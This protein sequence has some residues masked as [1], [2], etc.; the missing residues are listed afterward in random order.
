VLYRD[1][2]WYNCFQPLNYCLGGIA[3]VLSGRIGGG[4]AFDIDKPSI[5]AVINRRGR[6][7][8]STKEGWSKVHEYIRRHDPDWFE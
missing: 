5:F 8:Y 7:V 4:P 6:E 3:L 1:T 2:F